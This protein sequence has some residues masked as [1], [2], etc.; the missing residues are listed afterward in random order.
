MQLKNEK[1]K[2]NI[3]NAREM[4]EYTKVERGISKVRKP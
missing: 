1:K 4:E 3:R 2:K